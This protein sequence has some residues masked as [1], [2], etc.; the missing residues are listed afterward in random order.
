MLMNIISVT[1]LVI[2]II[3]YILI[4]LVNSQLDSLGSLKL[5]IGGWLLLLDTAV[6]SVLSIRLYIKLK[7][8][9]CKKGGDRK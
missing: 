3:F 2:L 4:L 1:F 6:L 8:D 5:S 9:E 7:K